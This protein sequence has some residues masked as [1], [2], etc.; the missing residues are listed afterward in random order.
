MY[1][2]QID[3]L[4][5][6]TLNKFYLTLD[7]DGF[8]KKIL[9]D[10]NF[11]KYQNIILKFIQTFVNT[12]QKKEIFAIVKNDSYVDLI[13]NIIKRYCAFYIYIGLSYYYTGTHS[14]FITNLI[15]SSKYQKDSTIQITNFFNSE[16]NSKIIKFYYDIKN[17]L[18]LFDFKTI[19]KI[20]ILLLNNPLKYES[21]IKI[22]N[23]LG[24]DYIINNFL[25]KDNFHNII[26]TIIFRYIYINEEKNEI[27]KL[28]NQTEIDNAEYKYI[29]IITSNEH[30]MIN[31]NN[32]MKLLTLPELKNSDVEDIYEY[33]NNYEEIKEIIIKESHDFINY[34][35]INKILIPITEDFLRFHKNTE[36][37]EKNNNEV[38]SYVKNRESTKIKF[39][40]NKM[41][42]IINYYSPI[43]E[44]NPKLKLETSNLF[45]KQL[46][47]RKV[48]LYNDDEELKIIQK[49]DLSKDINDYDL[50][51]DLKNIRK[52]SYINFKNF[53]K[54]GIKIRTPNTIEC[55]RYINVLDNKL[56]SLE[57]RICNDNIDINVIGVA[58]NP[59][60]LILETLKFNNLVDV[61]K[62]TKEENGFI[63]FNK[64]LNTDSKKGDKKIYYWL[65]NNNDKPEL[66]K[67]IDINVN[68]PVNNIKVMLEQLYYNYIDIQKNKFIKYI[69][70]LKDLSFNDLDRLFKVYNIKDLGNKTMNELFE[71]LIETKIKEYDIIVDPVHSMIPGKNNK[72]VKLPKLSDRIDNKT[73][74]NI[75]Y[76]EID[77]SLEL[78]NKIIPMCN[79]Y[80]KWNN[81]NKLYKLRITNF[82]QIIFDFTQQYVKI[83][84]NN[85]YICKSCNEMLYLQ[86]FVQE[87][88]YDKELD[89]FLT[90]SLIITEKFEDNPKY[91]KYLRII[92]NLEKNIEK[93]AITINLLSYIGNDITT[94]L[95]RK[96]I[97]KDII[98][99]I[100]VHTEWLKTQPKN[101]IE[102]FNKKYNTNMTNL[103]FFELKDDIFLTKS[104]ET[105][106]YKI[107]KYNNIIAYLIFI[108]ITDMNFGQ[109][110]SLKEDKKYNYFIYSKIGKTL[111]S[112]L[113][114]RINQTQKIPIIDIPILSYLLY[115][116]SGILINNR[117]WLWNNNIKIRKD[118]KTTINNDNS[119]QK[120]QKEQKEQT[121]KERE[122]DLR[123]KIINIQKNIIHTVIDL[124]NTICEVNF[125]ID[126]NYLYAILT[127]RFFTDKLYNTYNDKNLLK[128]I[129]EISMKNINIDS[130]TNKITF[131]VRKTYLVNIDSSYEFSD[132]IS[133]HRCELKISKTIKQNNTINN[134]KLNL[135]SNCPDG[136]FHNWSYKNSD[137]I[138]SLCNQ[139]YNNLVKILET[140]TQS[141]ETNEHIY[142]DKLKFIN[143]KKLTYKYC[144][145]GELH[146]FIKDKCVKCGSYYYLSSICLDNKDKC[147]TSN[148]DLLKLENNLSNKTYEDSIESINKLKLEY[149]N[150]QKQ[151]EKVIKIINDFNQQYENHTKL[152]I[153]NYID[154]FI[155]RIIKIIGNKIKSLYF[156]D[157]IYKIDHDYLGNILKEPII[158]S[159]TDDR[160][161]ISKNHPIFNK[162]VLYYKNKVNNVI[163]YYDII[164]L[165]YLGY[166][167]D[168]KMLKKTNNIRSLIVNVSLCDMIQF[169]GFNNKYIN[170]Y[171]I[172]KLYQNNLPNKLTSNDIIDI[173]RDRTNNLKQIISRIQTIIYNIIN[174]KIIH[175][176]SKDKEIIN[177]FINKIKKIN[178]N[179]IFNNTNEII[180]NLKINIIPENFNLPLIKNYVDI[181]NLHTLNNIDNYLLFF[182]I[183]NFNKLLDNNKDNNEI[184]YLITRI[185]YHLFSS[186]YVS[187]SDYHIQRFDILLFTETPFIDEKLKPT[188]YYQ[189][190]LNKEEIDDP[191]RQD[192][193][194]DEEQAKDSL[195]IDDYDVDDDIDEVG[196]MMDGG[197]EE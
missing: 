151:K 186:Y 88:S 52:Y 58:Y 148:K 116:L 177:E 135:L 46:E 53:S 79:H 195:D 29:E 187:Y 155:S 119:E 115:Y 70:K 43:I 64:I 50:S 10:S 174:K 98:D 19:D 2:N 102:E 162:D 149:E 23:D 48:V 30:K 180:N 188:G 26:K 141:S 66:D 176:N 139:S 90:T 96:T 105:D 25:K 118:D 168:N 190:L 21:T 152:K 36:K 169:L 114:L 37:Y 138:C 40:I 81:I 75:G 153:N 61:R 13:I 113:Y 72:I 170:L 100:L 154:D 183:Y 51:I 140:T 84:S 120:E 107:I 110:I 184:C 112:G 108:I 9:E 22:F 124:M 95:R 121:K 163:V 99:L 158:L 57:T 49:L 133:K 109:L 194:Y 78:S 185:I 167:Y 150:K 123:R 47:E 111:F 60:N 92:R 191:E 35:F 171:H 11:I 62:I 3:E 172:N 33:L 6:N 74:I 125:N 71:L 130:A 197:F 179:D 76:S 181:T 14:L 85:E 32:I 55:I 164:T 196:E 4:I 83:N 65:F 89:V 5:D 101:R 192:N 160:I 173:I 166:S 24:E 144:I 44:S 134:N 7:K 42:N 175:T 87:G 122:D 27:I 63:A 128:K 68:D 73:I 93:I 129:E 18:F 86:K 132:N 143:L 97:I 126:K 104:N 31:F 91:S 15:E 136:K 77:V 8:M 17:F 145:S 165:Q 59:S 16:N 147:T 80:Y 182:I 69:D 45:Y 103:F 39:I 94:K 56:H 38:N 146:D 82:N 189:E 28:L 161:H 20:K 67:Y 1:V 178:M 117:I 12:I 156:K 34:L 106:Y 127:A 142:L 54:N 131:I 157:T 137:L 193:K 41:N 159:S